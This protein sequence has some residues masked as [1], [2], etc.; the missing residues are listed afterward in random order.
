MGRDSVKWSLRGVGR[1]L[2]P[3]K[4]GPDTDLI[5]THRIFLKKRDEKPNTYVSRLSNFEQKERWSCHRKKYLRYLDFL[6]SRWS[7]EPSQ[8]VGVRDVQDCF[9]SDPGRSFWVS[10][11]SSTNTTTKFSNRSSVYSQTDK[12]PKP[13][14]KNPK[15][16]GQDNERSTQWPVQSIG[17]TRTLH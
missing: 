6:C 5:Y 16:F 8:G 13:L 2:W 17:T 12:P 9:L 14:K 3:S 4:I 11:C 7:P 15:T 10:W 1:E